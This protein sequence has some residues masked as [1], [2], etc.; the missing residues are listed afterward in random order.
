VGGFQRRALVVLVRAAAATAGLV[1][2]ACAFICAPMNQA[3]VAA[4]PPASMQRATA[5]SA[6]NDS[7]VPA[8]QRAAA[9]PPGR[10]LTW[11]PSTQTN[12]SSGRRPRA[13]PPAARAARLPAVRVHRHGRA[14]QP[15][16]GDYQREP[17]GGDERR[18][19]GG[20]HALRDIQVRSC[21]SVRF[22]HRLLIT[23]SRLDSQ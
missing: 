16:P 11:M 7:K 18:D 23:L 13:P 5:A 10:A 17:P 2:S 6:T 8:S 22:T 4:S 3:A 1:R 21:P 9:V 20:W 12:P 15:P 14:L 19:R